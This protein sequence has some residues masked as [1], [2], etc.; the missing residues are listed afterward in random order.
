MGSRAAE[1]RNEKICRT[2][3]FYVPAEA[4]SAE[5]V[6]FPPEEE[7]HLR[8]VLRLGSGVQVE[9]LDGC[10]ARYR[11]AVESVSRN[12]E[13][14]GRILNVER[15]QPEKPFISVALS[16]GRR[17]RTRVAVEK[18]A[19]L[20]CHRIMPLLTDLSSCKA[21]PGH[22][23]EKLAA[24][25][26]SALKQSGNLYLTGIETP[27]SFDEFTALAGKGKIN[28]VFCLKEPE[29]ANR[30]ADDISK[31]A[32]FEEYFLVVGPEGGFSMREKE[33]I[34]SLATPRLHLGSADLR[35]ETA[36]VAGF[37]M[38]RQTLRRDLYFY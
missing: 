27:K 2:T 36:A 29:G 13:L 31:P 15:A 17:E 32:A 25:C 22:Q 1:K 16:L 34:E 21:D 5:R 6:C 26:I 9:V 12:S 4:V 24:V 37:V 14:T 20:G 28:P 33:L 30:R 11:V 19:E 10:G 18:L 3:A 35:L 8:H 7:H 23:V 38:L